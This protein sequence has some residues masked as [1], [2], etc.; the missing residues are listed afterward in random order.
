MAPDAAASFRIPEHFPRCL[1]EAR[2]L[3]FPGRQLPAEASYKVGEPAGL[4][5]AGNL[6]RVFPRRD[7]RR[8]TKEGNKR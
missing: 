2:I 7:G 6:S 4:A 5:H 8:A 1:A 3:Q